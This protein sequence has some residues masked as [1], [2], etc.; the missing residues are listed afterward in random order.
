MTVAMTGLPAPTCS[1]MLRHAPTWQASA[2]GRSGR[3][4]LRRCSRTRERGAI[5][6]PLR[7]SVMA[8]DVSSHPDFAIVVSGQKVFE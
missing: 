8:R 6:T 1:D 7:V 5:G 3:C 2:R 4:A